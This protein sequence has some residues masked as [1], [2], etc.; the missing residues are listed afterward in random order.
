MIPIGLWVISSSDCGNLD[1]S[2]SLFVQAI[3]RKSTFAHYGLARVLARRGKALEAEAEFRKVL[4]AEPNRVEAHYA[5]AWL[6]RQM[7]RGRMPIRVRHRRGDTC[8]WPV[9]PIPKR[10]MP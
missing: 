2:E 8:N 7:G 6:H 9:V 3:A 1:A 10:A 4:A 5:L